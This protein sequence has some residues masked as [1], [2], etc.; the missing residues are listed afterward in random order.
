MCIN[1]TF[2]REKKP[3]WQAI[4]SQIVNHLCCILSPLPI[5]PLID[6]SLIYPDSPTSHTFFN[7]SP[8]NFPNPFLSPTSPLS[9]TSQNLSSTFPVTPFPFFSSG[10][11]SEMILVIVEEREERE[12]VG[13][14]KE[15]RREISV[16]REE[17]AG[18]VVG[19]DSV[20]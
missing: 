15:E 1:V 18:W 16:R 6:G 7:I 9:T 4:A 17:W 3:H 14:S 10:V 20:A 2:R 12:R 13:G 8:T 5:C 19:K 11:N